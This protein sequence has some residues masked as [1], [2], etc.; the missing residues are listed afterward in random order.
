MSNAT[1]RIHSY[2]KKVITR[3]SIAPN[4][5]NNEAHL[6]DWEECCGHQKPICKVFSCTNQAK[7]GAHMHN[8]DL[9][10]DSRYWVVPVCA[11]HLKQA[12]QEL[13]FK[14]DTFGMFDSP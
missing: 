2:I 12:G 13:H 9:G 1:G 3:G 14:T 11:N 5:P 4:R 10:S 8:T 6:K 7:I